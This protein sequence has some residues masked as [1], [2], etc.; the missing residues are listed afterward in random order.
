MQLLI[1]FLKVLL[2]LSSALVND[3]AFDDAM[4]LIWLK[5]TDFQKFKKKKDYNNLWLLGERLCV[6][7]R[8]LCVGSGIKW[9]VSPIA[10]AICFSEDAESLPDN[11]VS[12]SR[13]NAAKAAKYS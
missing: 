12:L 2:I 13:T 1:S 7:R 3:V 10:R 4:Q 9:I 5:T 6:T 8:Q 11:K